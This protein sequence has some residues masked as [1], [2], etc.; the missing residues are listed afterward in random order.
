[1]SNTSSTSASY[2]SFGTI[3]VLGG[4]SLNLIGGSF[5]INNLV[6]GAGSSLNLS[7]INLYYTSLTNLGGSYSGGQL[8]QVADISEVPEPGTVLLLAT[9]F[10]GLVGLRRRFR[11]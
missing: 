2:F 6:L 7:G 5:Y 8:L 1:M 10:A 3:E 9:G 11:A 4:G